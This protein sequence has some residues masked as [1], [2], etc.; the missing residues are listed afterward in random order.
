MPLQFS[1][2]GATETVT[3]LVSTIL[4]GKC[5][6]DIFIERLLKAGGDD[7]NH[8][9][10]AASVFAEIVPTAALFSL[11]LTHAVNYYLDTDT[12]EKQAA[13]QSINK[14]AGV[15][16]KTAEATLLAYIYIALRTPVYYLQ[17]CV[18]EA[19]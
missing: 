12:E 14:N 3:G 4:S 2:T 8:H 15:L 9:Q 17:C 10:L 11:Y 6:A 1:V 19:L 18:L 13:R 5:Y 16:T 7:R